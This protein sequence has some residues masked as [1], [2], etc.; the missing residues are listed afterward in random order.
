M[1][2]QIVLP[3]ASP[4]VLPDRLATSTFTPANAAS[5]WLPNCVS[6]RWIASATM[7]AS[8]EPL[9]DSAE[10]LGTDAVSSVRSAAVI[11]VPVLRELT[12]FE[13]VDLIV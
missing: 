4:N 3:N 11:N 7:E 6:R 10:P 1:S 12:P 9:S 8:C 2:I 13:S 5:T